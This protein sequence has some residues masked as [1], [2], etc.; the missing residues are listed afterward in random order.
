MPRRSSTWGTRRDA[1]ML[2][3]CVV[4]SSPRGRQA[5]GVEEYRSKYNQTTSDLV[6]NSGVVDGAVCA[7]CTTVR[8]VR[9][10][11][12]VHSVAVRAIQRCP[13]CAWWAFAQIDLILGSFHGLGLSPK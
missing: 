8:A 12:R 11:C 6:L 4:K 1:R 10:V 3:S 7:V 5:L 13:K 2:E 9:I